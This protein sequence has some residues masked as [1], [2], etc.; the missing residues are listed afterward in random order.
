[1][2][3]RKPPANFFFFLQIELLAV[4]KGERAMKMMEQRERLSETFFD[5]LNFNPG[6][7]RCREF[8]K[9]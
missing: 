3:L 9:K 7:G 8:I 2:P 1:M 4:E 6:A 5:L